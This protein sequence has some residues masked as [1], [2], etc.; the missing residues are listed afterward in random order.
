MNIIKAIPLVAVFAC[1]SWKV[2]PADPEVFPTFENIGIYWRAPPPLDSNGDARLQFRKAGE[3]QWE[4][5]LPLGF[6]SREGEYRGSLVHLSPDTRYEIKVTH[7]DSASDTVAARTWSEQFPIASVVTLPQHSGETLTI[8]QSGSPS[9]Y[10]LFT[11]GPDSSATIDVAKQQDF[12]VRIQASYVIVR[13][14]RL[15]GA[16]MHGVVIGDGSGNPAGISNVVI[17]GN[18]ISDWG[19]ESAEK[20]GFGRDFDSAIFSQAPDLK[21]VVIQRNR[22]HH[23]SYTAISR[24]E[25]I[26]DAA[27]AQGPVGI[28]LANSEGHLVIRYNE[29]YSD[30]GRYFRD[31]ISGGQA[32]SNTGFPNRNSDIHGNYVA[33][34]WDDAIEASG[35]NRNVRVWGN[36]LDR[37]YSPIAMA[38]NY[39]GPLYIWRNVSH[40][41]ASGPNNVVGSAFLKIRNVDPV[42]DV[43]W[44][45]GSA[46]VFNN[47][48]LIP[49][50]GEGLAHFIRP[51]GPADP[52]IRNLRSLN[53]LMMV[54]SSGFESIIAS[55]AAGSTFD[56][57]LYNGRISVP[58]GEEAHGIQG[59][60][61]LVAD[62]GFDPATGIGIFALA[63]DSPGYD[64]GV[65]IPNFLPGF[66]GL[67][68]DMGAQEA[69]A[70]PQEFGT[71]AHVYG[72]ASTSS[73][74]VQFSAAIYPVS[75]SAAEARVTVVRL[76]G[77]HGPASVKL[78][79]TAGGTAKPGQ[80][81]TAVS[82]L[83]DW[84]D[85]DAAS[86]TFRIP[87]IDD[88]LGEVDGETVKLALT[89]AS[90][91]TLGRSVFAEVR[92]E[93]DDPPPSA[94]VLQF[95]APRYPVS[96]SASAVLITVT[97]TGGSFGEAGVR[98]R[99]AAGGT[100]SAGSDY[101]ETSGRLSWRDGDARSKTVRIPLLKDRL[102]EPDVETVRLLLSGAIG[103]GLGS[104]AE[105]ELAIA[106]NDR[107]SNIRIA[108]VGDSTVTHR[109]GWGLGLEARA[110]DKVTVLNRAVSGT[111]SK[112]YR[113]LG[114]WDQALAQRPDYMLIQFGH[115]DQPG[116]SPE[117]TTDPDTTYRDN[118]TRYVEEARAVGIKPI[119]VTSLTRRKF[120]E[121]GRIR[122]DLPLTPYAAAVRALAPELG[123]PLVDLHAS[124]IFYYNLLGPERSQRLAPGPKDIT[125]LNETGSYRISRLVALGL[126]EELRP[127][128]DDSNLR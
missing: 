90:G 117:K 82:I 103:A 11:A 14:L 92:I 123:I 97:R 46:Y 55:S 38:P 31:G 73:G 108:L 19:S 127:Y 23:P 109:L 43:N 76:G 6:D 88:G 122:L 102:D 74:V 94:G 67:G 44:G 81:Y 63:A 118:M 32:F 2:C 68:P 17:E 99:T 26:G 1:I 83:I 66:T 29:L 12:N 70:S 60:A 33:N 86:R 15:K 124:S 10:V 49:S 114:F 95:S 78:R 64:R 84:A 100:A 106:D 120:G 65:A 80:D 40:S 56:Y 9:G 45:G 79:T 28:A 126:P 75:E 54:R 91:A 36:Y 128:F 62:W 16:R 104:L 4:E 5:G 119:L 7:D 39:G 47:S 77:S 113:D 85:G 96:E 69:S 41:I 30:A 53:N 125:H 59:T 121:N 8:T 20:P 22:I 61:R 18:D 87:L 115:N 116:K 48:A 34:V 71:Q 37:I 21:R 13:G 89:N 52:D 25:N 35:A 110:G 58:E 42:T 51:S 57:D 105:A 24:E 3:A 50:V 107:G 27:G 72:P 93:D 112:S 101:V 111:S 98:F